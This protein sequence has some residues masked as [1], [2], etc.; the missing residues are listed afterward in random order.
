MAVTRDQRAEG[1]AEV[2]VFRSVRIPNPRALRLANVERVRIDE[3][4]V[5]VHPEGDPLLRGLHACADFFVRR[6]NAWSSSS[7]ECMISISHP[8]ERSHSINGF[9]QHM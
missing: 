8:L 6:R 5:A 4:V 7:H 3:T 9:P 2:D 1:H